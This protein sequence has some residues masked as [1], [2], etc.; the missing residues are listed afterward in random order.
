VKKKPSLS[1]LKKK[2][3]KL[4][5]EWVRRKDADAGGT[6]YCFTCEKPFYWKSLQAGHGIPGRHNAVLF[7]EEI[8]KP[9]CPTCNIWKRGMHHVFA[10]K[11]IQT[12]GMDWWE[13]KLDGARAV[14]KLTRTDI[15]EMIQTYKQKL[16]AL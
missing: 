5:S 6:E 2:C 12:H 7:D 8:V 1:S 13:K 10:T 15:E 14:V 3:W 11:L 9:Q 16:A 4:F